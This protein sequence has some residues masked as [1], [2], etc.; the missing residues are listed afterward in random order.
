[1]LTYIHRAEIC[2]AYH[3][4]ANTE[5]L[6]RPSGVISFGGAY[7]PWKPLPLLGL[8][9][10]STSSAKTDGETR[11]TSK[12]TASL[13]RE[14]RGTDEPVGAWALRLTDSDGTRLILGTS[15]EDAP[16]IA[17]ASDRPSSASSAVRFSLTAEW[18]SAPLTEL[19]A[20]E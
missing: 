7:I 16:A 8:A 6:S 15:S 2:P 12:L 5:A 3:L 1:M 13:S 17:C 18:F 9:Q 4:A 20:V 14:W 10:L 19:Q 11:H